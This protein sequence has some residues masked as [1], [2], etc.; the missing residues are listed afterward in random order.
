MLDLFYEVR[1]H[2]IYAFFAEGEPPLALQLLVVNTIFFMVFI[3]RRMRGA[4][5]LRSETAMVVQGLLLFA[6][7]AIL[8]QD[9]FWHYKD[10]L[11]DAIPTF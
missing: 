6:N 11:I 7:A 2:E 3:Q 8:F 1:W 10:R 4:R 9:Y 5:S